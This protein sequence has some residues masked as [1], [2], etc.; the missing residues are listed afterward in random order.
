MVALLINRTVICRATGTE[1]HFFFTF[2]SSPRDKHRDSGLLSRLP[3]E[4]SDAL[5]G[6]N[7]Q[8]CWGKKAL[9][10]CFISVL[11][12]LIVHRLKHVVA[13]LKKKTQTVIKPL[14]LFQWQKSRINLSVERSGNALWGNGD[15][16]E[17]SCG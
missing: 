16:T 5:C 4:E 10:S 13:N 9:Q 17:R 3:G 7:N 2:F 6:G 14:Q 11:T 1:K 12:A 15:E 8:L